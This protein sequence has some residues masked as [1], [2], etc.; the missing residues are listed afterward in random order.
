M[1]QL[2]ILLVCIALPLNLVHAQSFSALQNSNFNGVHGIYTNP[3]SVT[4]MTHKRSANIGTIGFELTN[5][6]LT[7]DA[8]FSMWSLVTGNVSDQYRKPNGSVDWQESWIKTDPNATGVNVNMSSEFRGPSYVNSYGRFTWG[9]ATRTRTHANI[10]NLNPGVWQFVKQWID[11][12]E[13]TNPLGLAAQ[14]FGFSANSYQE[15][16]AVLGLQLVNSSTLKLGVATTL[17]G[18]LGLGSVNI[19]NTGATFQAIGM[20][21]LAMTSGRMEFAYTDNNLLQQL[22]SGVF[23]GSLPNLNSIT[24]I[25][26]GIDLGVAMEFGTDMETEFNNRQSFR[27][28]NFKVGAAILDL[29]K[30]SYQNQNEGY[31]IDA[32]NQTFKLPLNSL[33]FVQALE[34]GSQGV[35]D[36]AIEAAKEQNV[37]KSNNEKTSVLLPSTLQL[38]FDW[39]VIPGFYV[40]G[41]WQQ[42][43]HFADKWEFQQNSTVS[44]VPRFEHKWFEFSVPLRYQ[45]QFNRISMGAHTRIGPVFFG[46]DNMGN[47]FKVSTYSGMTFYMGISTLMK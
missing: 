7:L 37:L 31:I 42:A 11:S 10:S 22:F 47:I 34:S 44:I 1:R 5:D 38:Q 46:S 43:L 40:A 17:K 15:I 25:G 13:I 28:Y 23:S 9:T 20:D 16:S 21:T 41:H 26:Y 2:F 35:I 32:D 24:G 45:Q 27:D 6:Y 18:I 19:S 14:P 33:A 8:P 3:A 39:R 12:Q 36:Y 29:G 4:L 30:V